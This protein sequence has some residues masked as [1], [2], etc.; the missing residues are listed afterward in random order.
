LRSFII[1][2]LLKISTPAATEAEGWG[3]ISPNQ[4]ETRQSLDG[5]LDDK[6]GQ[7]AFRDRELREPIHFCYL[8]IYM[9]FRNSGDEKSIYY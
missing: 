6:L 4:S 2:I 3:V 8:N 5:K 1:P 9:L 7:S